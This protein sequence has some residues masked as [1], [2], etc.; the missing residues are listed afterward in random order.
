MQTQ[1]GVSASFEQD[2][3]FLEGAWMEQKLG[4]L[5]KPGECRFLYRHRKFLGRFTSSRSSDPKECWKL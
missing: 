4:L 1:V 3:G 2:Y 5:T